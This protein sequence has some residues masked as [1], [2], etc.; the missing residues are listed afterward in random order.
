MGSSRKGGKSFTR[1]GYD[2]RGRR[3]L[4][5]LAPDMEESIQAP[6]RSRYIAIGGRSGAQ[7]LLKCARHVALVRKTAA[8][9]NLLDGEWR[10]CQKSLRPCE[11]PLNDVD[12]RRTAEPP[13]ELP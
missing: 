9:R 10:L 6:S 5:G 4:N 11:T 8:G 12:V 3:I 13:F 7:V 1:Q 2:N